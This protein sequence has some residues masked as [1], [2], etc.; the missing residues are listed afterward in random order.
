ME[1]K[2]SKQDTV[3]ILE[4]KGRDREKSG[5]KK[6]GGK[7][8]RIDYRCVWRLCSPGERAGVHLWCSF[9]LPVGRKVDF[10]LSF[11]AL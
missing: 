3:L 9:T 2:F 8:V 10:S 4:E 6:K 7:S 11:A 1:L 5:E